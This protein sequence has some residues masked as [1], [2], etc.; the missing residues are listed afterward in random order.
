[1]VKWYLLVFIASALSVF[2]Q[3]HT[4]A[5]TILQLTEGWLTEP[6]SVLEAGFSTFVTVV[7]G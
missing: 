7:T 1:M 2:L 4:V 6:N 3:L 5:L